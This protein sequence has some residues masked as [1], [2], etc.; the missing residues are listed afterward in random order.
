M[1]IADALAQERR[2]RLAAKGLLELKQSELFAANAKLSDHALSLSEEIV[3]KREEV[4]EVRTEAEELRGQNTQVREDLEQA[5]QAVDIAERRLW[6]SVETIGDG[7]VVF[8]PDSILVAANSAFLSVFDGIECVAP[9]VSYSEIVRIMVE[10]GIVDTEPQKPGEWCAELLE[11]WNIG[12][13]EPKT[14]KLWNGQFV[15]LADRR[16]ANGDTV[17]LALNI[18]DT[19]RR[20]NQLKDARVRAEAANR[21]KSAFL[22]KMSH[23]LRTPMN[24]VV[25][26]ADLLADTD[27][28]EE[29]SLFA[30]TIKKT[31]GEA[32]LVLINDVLDFSK[33]EAEKLVLHNEVFDLEHMLNDIVMLFQP[34]VLGKDVDLLIDYDIFLPTAFV[35]DP[36][37]V[38]QVLTNLIGNAV[39]F[40]ASGHILIR[41]VGL[42]QGETGK[43]RVHV[44]IED[45]GPGI[46]ADVV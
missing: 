32:L 2:A 20:E 4:A 44:T 45:T 15:K 1:S 25:G 30:E 10:E 13:L 37:R 35:C 46:P 34:D 43:F 5:H 11:R 19:I 22:A 24:G 31:S 9:G 33:I 14:I 41:V 29:Q 16:S 17:S 23:E 40:T 18:T 21:A 12:T 27:L 7:F 28:T 26:M 8:D 39:K 3:D 36:G 42:P 38:R 6:D